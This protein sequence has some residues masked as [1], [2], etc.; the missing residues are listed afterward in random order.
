MEDGADGAFAI[1][2]SEWRVLCQSPIRLCWGY[3]TYLYTSALS[4]VP[5]HYYSHLLLPA[6]QR[7]G[8]QTC[9]FGCFFHS[10]QRSVFLC[11]L[12]PH[13]FINGLDFE[14]F[15]FR[16][17]LALMRRFRLHVNPVPTLHQGWHLRSCRHMF[18]FSN[19]FIFNCLLQ[20]EICSLSTSLHFHG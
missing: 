11:S 20:N 17:D 3:S 6:C 10:K 2:C 1:F 4:Q 7:V 5:H 12:Y 18:Y 15:M 8:L 19:I 16:P 13:L 14:S 9:D